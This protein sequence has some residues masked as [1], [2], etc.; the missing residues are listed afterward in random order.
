MGSTLKGKNL[1][2]NWKESDSSLKIK[3][4]VGHSGNQTGSHKSFSFQLAKLV[5]KHGGLTIY[6]KHFFCFY[7]YD[8]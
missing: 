4:Q 6:L 8:K 7:L 2:P 5:S 3:P 1:G